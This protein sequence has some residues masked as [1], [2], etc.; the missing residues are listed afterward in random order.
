MAF[1]LTVLNH[2]HVYYFICTNSSSSL[3]SEVISF[4]S[5]VHSVQALLWGTPL[6]PNSRYLEMYFAYSLF[7]EAGGGGRSGFN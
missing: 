7:I 6:V 5:I 3:P 2:L 1:M 4:L